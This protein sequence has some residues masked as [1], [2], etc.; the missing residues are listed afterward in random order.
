MR[1][2]VFA[3]TH[4]HVCKFMWVH[5][6]VCV[7]VSHNFGLCM[8]G[9]SQ[10]M[11][12]CVCFFIPAGLACC[13]KLNRQELNPPKEADT[14]THTQATVYVP[15]FWSHFVQLFIKRIRRSV[16]FMNVCSLQ[17]C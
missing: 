10:T 9:G 8:L 2:C 11:R 3:L 1:E 13:T 16:H 12:E 5:Q 15:R 14:R 7:C 6:C 4:S 17:Q